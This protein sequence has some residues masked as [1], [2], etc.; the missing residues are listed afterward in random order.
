MNHILIVD[1]SATVRRHLATVLSSAGFAVQTVA[2]GKEALVSYKTAHA[3]L[4]ILDVVMPD[5][6]GLE[7][8]QA[9]RAVDSGVKVVGISGIDP[10]F[11]PV[12][13]KML[14]LLGAQ[15]ILEKPFSD[16][17]LIE[18]VR[19]LLAM[20]DGSGAGQP[21]ASSPPIDPNIT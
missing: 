16:Q 11:S 18:T 8:L 7:T 4:V 1:D 20:P 21:S 17:I 5:M 2:G 13:L 3:S 6:D 10:R 14:R 19:R 12:Y 15:A 9:L